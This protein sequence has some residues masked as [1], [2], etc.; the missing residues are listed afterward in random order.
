MAVVIVESFTVP[1]MGDSVS[2]FVHKLP[3][4][5]SEWFDIGVKKEAV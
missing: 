5:P 2:A 1:H 4:L 3:F